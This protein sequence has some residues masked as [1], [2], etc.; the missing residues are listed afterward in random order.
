MSFVRS[1]YIGTY[2]QHDSFLPKLMVCRRRA[3]D[4][5]VTHPAFTTQR[6]VVRPFAG[7][8]QNTSQRGGRVPKPAW[9]TDHPVSVGHI[10]TIIN[11]QVVPAYFYPVR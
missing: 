1:V 10:A 3:F 11:F 9:E 2:D 8:R 6:C 7:K 5:A 4:I